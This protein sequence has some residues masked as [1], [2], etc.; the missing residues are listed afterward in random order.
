VNTGYSLRIVAQGLEPNKFY[1]IEVIGEYT[2]STGRKVTTRIFTE[3][4]ITDA[5]GTIDDEVDIDNEDLL[6]ILVSHTISASATRRPPEDSRPQGAGNIGITSEFGP[7]IAAPGV[8]VSG[9]V[10]TP[11]GLG[12]RNRPSP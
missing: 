3:L 12:L 9:R 1:D 7:A 10:T 4:V 11:T 5:Q 6:A 8:Q 2:D